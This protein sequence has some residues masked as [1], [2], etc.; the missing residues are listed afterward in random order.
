MY[1]VHFE[2][3]GST[4]KATFEEFVA[5]QPLPLTDLE[6]H[7]E[8][9]CMYFMIGGR[10]T[11]GGL[12]RVTYAGKDSTAPA[13]LDKNGISART[14]RKSLEKYHGRKDPKAVNAAWSH[15]GSS[16]RYIRYAARTAIEHQP[17]DQWREKALVEKD[18]QSALSALLAL[19]RVG[20]TKDQDGVLK[21]LGNM[22]WEK[23]STEQRLQIIR[24]Y[25]LCFI[26]LGEPDKETRVALG[27][28]LVANLPDRDTF[29][30]EELVQLLVYLQSPDVAPKAVALLDAAPTQEEQI[31]YVKS[32]RLLRE[33]WDAD[34]RKSYY[35]WFGR[36][37]GYR[38]GASFK[39]FLA[40]IQKDMEMGLM[41]DEKKAFHDIIAAAP[42]PKSP[43]DALSTALS[44][45]GF[46]E[47]WQVS[48]F[49]EE[50]KSGLNGRNF[51]KGKTLFGA[52][53]CFACHRFQGDGGSMGPDL[54]GSAGRFSAKDLLESI[55]EPSKEVSDQYAPIV[56]KMKDGTTITGRI[57]NMSGDRL[58]VAQDMFDPQN[59]TRVDRREVES[60]EY[61]KISPMP[62][63]LLGRL[64]KGE[65]LDLLA[66]IISGGNQEHAM[67]K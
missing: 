45:R 22:K 61:S 39:N 35:Q 42:E 44:G 32:L 50:F 1:A 20:N 25:S 15:L 14:I 63:M 43:L 9:K 48:H 57:G 17:V 10:R 29:V 3:D 31:H 55:V 51:E 6:I 66:Y 62:P 49:E 24:I 60:I 5:G 46:V 27:K 65:V 53:A 28:S 11:Q 18:T 54:T 23:L 59:F 13:K 67:F 12:Y 41:G 64:E 36:A 37:K 56:I 21:S 40:D 4:Y 34:S 30:N 38:G 16:D 47:N 26:R 52:T 2:P 58:M 7:Q 19:V 8:H 33:G